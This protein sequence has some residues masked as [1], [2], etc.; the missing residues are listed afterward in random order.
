MVHDA[1]IRTWSPDIVTEVKNG[2]NGTNVISCSILGTNVVLSVSQMKGTSTKQLMVYV[3]EDSTSDIV[4]L[5]LDVVK[6]EASEDT[7][8]VVN[9]ES[10]RAQTELEEKVHFRFGVAVTHTY[11]YRYT[12]RYSYLY[13]YHRQDTNV[14]AYQQQGETLLLFTG[15][16]VFQ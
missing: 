5:A 10:M 1:H 12:Y 6:I 7:N 15:I 2:T 8:E 13:M 9:S 11:V 4:Y 14:L 16:H 3:S